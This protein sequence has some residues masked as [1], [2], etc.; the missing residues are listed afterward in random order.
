MKFSIRLKF[1]SQ[2]HDPV[3]LNIDYHAAFL[4][5]LKSGLSHVDADIFNQLYKKNTPKLYTLS[6]YF[7]QA[8]FSRSTVILGEQNNAYWQFSTENFRLGLSFYNA[9]VY[10]FQRGPW[11]YDKNYQ[12]VF[13]SPKQLKEPVITTNTIRAKTASPLVVRQDNHLFLSG[14]QAAN[15]TVFNTVLQGNMLSRFKAYYPET[16]CKMIKDLKFVP[17]NTRKTVVRSF[18]IFIEV[19]VGEFILYGDPVLLNLIV[20]NGLGIRTGNFSGFLEYL[21]G[22]NQ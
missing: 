4:Y 1:I 15:L 8:K 16:I 19:T 12:V 3:K 10:L 20:R 13:S 6:V 2:Q 5:L 14:T 22:E 7:P 21:G 9:F 11:A 17:I 18:G